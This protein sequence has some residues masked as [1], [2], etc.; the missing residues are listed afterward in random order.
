MKKYL[1]RTWV[2]KRLRVGK[3]S[4]D[5]KGV[6]ITADIKKGEKIMIWGGTI[7]PKNEYDDNKYRPQTIVPIDDNTYL[8]LPI[9]DTSQSADEF[10]NH[11]C[12]P[13]TWLI[14]E[15]T[16]VARRDI[17]KGEEITLDMAT[18]DAD[19]EWEYADE[20]NCRCGKSIC[21]KKLTPQDWMRKDIQ[22]RYHGHF[23]P[24]IEKKIQKLRNKKHK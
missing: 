2:D 13:N 14:D 15:V 9:K 1:E 17:N 7:I 24:Y 20:G 19:L 11:S 12:D 22:R 18:W 4:I 8:G 21:R 10:I 6:F 23:S 3:S 5:G 16:M